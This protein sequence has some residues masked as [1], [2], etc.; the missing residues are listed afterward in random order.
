[1]WPRLSSTGS[2]IVL[3]FVGSSYRTVGN[4]HVTLS[5]IPFDSKSAELIPSGLW[6]STVVE[7][8]QL[9][10]VEMLYFSYAI[11]SLGKSVIAP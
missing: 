9:V 8:V 2:Y 5:T 7:D 11:N 6:P 4:R 3:E 1:M 10:C